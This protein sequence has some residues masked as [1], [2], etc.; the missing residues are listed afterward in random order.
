MG[1]AKYV[2]AGVL[3]LLMLSG[4]ADKLEQAEDFAKS[5]TEYL[6]AGDYDT[7]R[8]QFNNAIGKN[9]E[10][11]EAH[12]GLADLAM[13]QKDYRKVVSSMKAVLNV[14]PVNYEA[15]M[16]LAQI[17]LLTA[18][19]S[20][21]L[22]YSE[23]ALQGKPDD[24]KALSLK[25]AALILNNRNEEAR[26][27]AGNV[28][29]K[30]P[31]NAEVYN[32]LA[33]DQ[34]SVENFE[35]AMK[36]LDEGIAKSE[37]PQGL[38]IVKLVLAERLNG[39]KGVM[40]VFNE[41]TERYPDALIYQIQKA[42]YLGVKMRDFDAGRKIYEAII[43]KSEESTGLKMRLAEFDFFAGD[44]EKALERI[45]GFIAEESDNFDLL[46]TRADL[47]C[48]SGNID[49]CRNEL[50]SISSMAPDDDIKN[51]ALNA[52]AFMALVEKDTSTANGLVEQILEADPNDP[53]ALVIKGRLLLADENYDEA[54]AV[55]TLA[56]DQEPD[57]AKAMVL[58]A[59]A[60]DQTG[61]DNFASAQYAKAVDNA[62]TDRVI[63]NAYQSFLLR[64]NDGDGAIDVA[65][66][67][68]EKRPGDI[69]TL[70]F[71]TQTQIAM[72]KVDEARISMER[73]RSVDPNND[74]IRL[75]EAGVLLLEKRYPA[76]LT[77]LEQLAE[78][79]PDDIRITTQLVDTYLRLNQYTEAENFLNS[80]LARSGDDILARKQFA[81]VL[82]RSQ[83]TD[84][85][86][87]VIEKLVADTPTDDAVHILNYRVKL[88]AGKK[89]LAL[90]SLREGMTKSDRQDRLEI[91]LSSE[92]ID[93]GEFQEAIRVLRKLN[94]QFPG[95]DVIAN[96]LANMLME[97]STDPVVLQEALEIAE[98]FRNSNTGY[99]LDTLAWAYHL[100][101]ETQKASLFSTRAAEALPNNPDVLYHHGIISFEAGE[102]EIGRAALE[103][104]L[105]IASPDSKV[106]DRA[107]AQGYL[108]Q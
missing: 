24:T 21:S 48:K 84:Q 62:K 36:I 7:A 6:E 53:D 42:E 40:E 65:N 107:K 44:P 100:N 12:L 54:I 66:T 9:Y 88:A 49:Q 1:K 27:V 87:S 50:K 74:K 30:D 43:P 93:A 63:T 82:L 35:E 32:I 25:A 39:N 99:Y 20:N 3:A 92:L 17:S 80:T 95:Q 85:A 64:K 71:L 19:K 37:D 101:G 77:I 11:I 69:P 16:A 97:T 18:D 104:A 89:A 2:T 13:R 14:D 38:L 91:L 60:Y 34:M 76:A 61:N 31:S 46:F 108:N 58:L 26:R 81:E 102:P 59:G 70:V 33:A 67:F 15:N 68:L 4:C 5:G 106:I 83:K 57:N 75:L 8:L 98:R 96:N 79:S 73:L 52:L 22:K 28:L 10:N 41:L 45:N 105:Q 72:G 56:L 55:L 23:G 47:Y 29:Q 78:E 51:Q 94:Q 103:K 86:N 90:Q